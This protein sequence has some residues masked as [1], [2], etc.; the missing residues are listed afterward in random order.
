MASMITCTEGSDAPCTKA[1]GTGACCYAL[2]C[3]AVV[4]SPTTVQQQAQ[5]ALK[6]VGFPVTKGAKMWGCISKDD[7][8][9]AADPSDPTNVKMKATEEQTGL[10]FKHYCDAATRL[11]ASAATAALII[12]SY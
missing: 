5:D 10:T 7:L 6:A 12:A 4:S 2:E 1:Y 3:T 8:A 11:V 9:K